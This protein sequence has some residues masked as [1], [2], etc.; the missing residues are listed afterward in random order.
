VNNTLQNLVTPED[1]EFFAAQ[2]FSMNDKVCD[3]PEADEE[4]RYYNLA[5][6][7]REFQSNFRLLSRKEIQEST[8]TLE[9]FSEDRISAKWESPFDK[10]DECRNEDE[11]AFRIIS[12]IRSQLKADFAQQLADRLEF[13][14]EVSHE[15]HPNE[16]AIMPESLSNF[17]ALLQTETHL[18][19]PDV[20]LSP[21][22]NIRVQWRTAP[23][24]HFAVE[25]L[26]SGDAQFVIFSPD[27]C[28]PEKTIRSSGIASIDSLMEIARAYGVLR[29]DS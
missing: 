14:Y 4:L 1:E 27:P 25:F 20:V 12:Y 19:Y 28:H 10:I 26:N 23:N 22:N 16:I 29:A 15:E 11:K 5:Y 21:S 7:W 13:L 17:V 2:Y 24:R 3:D 6:N 8:L 18:K 9:S